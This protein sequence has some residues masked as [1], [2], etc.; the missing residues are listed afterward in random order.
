M[1]VCVCVC[2]WPV[3]RLQPNH[4]LV[5]FTENRGLC[6]RFKHSP[7]PQ[8]QKGPQSSHPLTAN[9]ACHLMWTTLSINYGDAQG[10]SNTRTA[11]PRSELSSSLTEAPLQPL[12]Q[13]SKPI[14]CR[15]CSVRPLTPQ[16]CHTSRAQA[17]LLLS[18]RDVSLPK[19]HPPANVASCSAL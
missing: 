15:R 17:F 19:A 16:S 18:S 12:L 1:C 3:P 14:C 8:L 7:R 5:S 9:G 6:W 10:P 2:A 11:A 13:S 4:R